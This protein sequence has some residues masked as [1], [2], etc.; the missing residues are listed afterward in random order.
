[1]GMSGVF[2]FDVNTIMEMIFD[3]ENLYY[4]IDGEEIYRGLAA[5]DLFDMDELIEMMLEEMDST[6]NLPEYDIGDIISVETT[7]YNGGERMI[8]IIDGN[9]LIDYVLETMDDVPAEMENTSIGDVYM[10]IITDS[11]GNPVFM[12]MKM[13]VEYIEDGETAKIDMTMT[14]TFNTLGYGVFIDI[15]AR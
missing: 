1:M 10:E 2:D 7:P 14:M 4:A 9:S 5:S 8:L 13:E 11:S 3:G 6:L 12:L 15:P